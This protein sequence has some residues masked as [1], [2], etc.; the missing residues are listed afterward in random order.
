MELNLINEIKNYLVE[1]VNL[2]HSF[3]ESISILND[4]SNKFDTSILDI[5]DIMK[6]L[7]IGN[8]YQIVSVVFDNYYELIKKDKFYNE[9]DNQFI[10][11]CIDAYCAF[12]NIELDI[13][14]EIDYDSTFKGSDSVKAYLNEIIKIPMLQE[15]EEKELLIRIK[16]GDLEARNKYIEANLRLV[17][18]I[19]KKYKAIPLIDAI[20]AGNHGLVTAVERYDLNKGAS[21]STYAYWWINQYIR[22]AIFQEKNIKKCSIDKIKKY[23]KTLNNLEKRLNREITTTE[24]AKEMNISELEVQRIENIIK[25]PVS[26]ETPINEGEDS[27]LKD[28]LASDILTPEEEFFETSK[29]EVLNDLF[30]K[31]GLTIREIKIL[32]YRYGFIDGY[33][34]VYEEIGNSYN[35]TR[36]RIRQIETKAIRKIKDY[37][38]KKKVGK[39]NSDSEN[40][41]YIITKL[42]KYYKNYTYEELEEVYNYLLNDYD[43][44]IIYLKV[45][46]PE[47][48]FEDQT[49]MSYYKNT[50]RKKI[51]ILLNNIRETKRYGISIKDSINKIDTLSLYEKIPEYKKEKIDEA[52][53]LLTP[54]ERDSILET[55]NINSSTNTLSFQEKHQIDRIILKIKLIIEKYYEQIA[56]IK[57]KPTIYDFFPYR[58]YEDINNAIKCLN[59]K[60]LQLI[61][62]I[63]GEKYN[64]L[65]L[66]KI[67][68]KKINYFFN[69][70]IYRINNTLKNNN[71]ENNYLL[72]K[73]V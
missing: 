18:S 61:L 39:D 23:Y 57:E 45:F 5:D 68:I 20:S 65:Y 52:I 22:Q 32:N 49:A 51:R 13:N 70:I 63:Y 47:L 19:A 46:K 14:E 44:N 53:K 73:Q 2:K 25:G 71:R 10:I 7:K 33:Y 54:S 58:K 24:I 31:A 35:L 36:E 11:S 15:K 56:I 67:S 6:L 60:G 4:I 55:F 50:L 17:I 21:F 30:E 72:K 64:N 38:E 40:V 8:F 9:V 28:L 41:E 34:H 37:L 59:K 42:L 48:L 1:N 29:K 66:E 43:K 12:N 26:I 69:V 27:T 3:K 16:N 62:E